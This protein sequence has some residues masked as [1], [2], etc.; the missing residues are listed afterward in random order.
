[1]E[2]VIDKV[3]QLIRRI[4]VYFMPTQYKLKS[5]HLDKDKVMIC[6]FISLNDKYKG[7]YMVLAD[8]IRRNPSYKH[9]FGDGA[10]LINLYSE[11]EKPI[12]HKWYSQRIGQCIGKRLKGY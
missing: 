8:M 3:K 7:R 9:I 11:E 12:Y 1:M 2:I 10:V 5:H 6:N 4:D